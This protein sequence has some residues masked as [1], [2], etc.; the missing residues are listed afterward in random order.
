M[1][2][3]IYIEGKTICIVGTTNSAICN[4]ALYIYMHTLKKKCIVDTNICLGVPLMVTT[5]N[6]SYRALYICTY[7]HIYICIVGSA[8][9]L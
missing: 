1:Y 9:C 5:Y 7:M 3:F 6:I 8:L 2:T 4:I